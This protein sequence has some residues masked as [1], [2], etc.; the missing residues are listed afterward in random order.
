MPRH[1]NLL[2]GMVVKIIITIIIIITYV[3]DKIFKYRF[4]MLVLLSTSQTWF[5]KIM[6]SPCFCIHFCNI[7]HNPKNTRTYFT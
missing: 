2:I 7:L 4:L 6:N 3:Y 1:N 5:H